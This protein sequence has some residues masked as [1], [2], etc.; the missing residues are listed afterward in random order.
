MDGHLGH[1]HVL[2]T[3]LYKDWGTHIISDFN[4][5]CMPR[6]GVAS[7]YDNA[8]FSCYCY[9]FFLGTSILFSKVAAQTYIPSS[10]VEGFLFHQNSLFV[11]FLL[12]AILIGVR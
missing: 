3:V 8:I 10:S 5:L 12:M 6:N 11:D 7:L 1:F 4:F 2:V 9:Y